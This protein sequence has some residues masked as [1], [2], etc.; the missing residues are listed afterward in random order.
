MEHERLQMRTAQVLT[1]LLQQGGE[2]T[3]DQIAHGL[4]RKRL[5]TLDLNALA[6]L[7]ASGRIIAEQRP[8]PRPVGYITVYRATK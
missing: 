5:N 8:G 6:R 7:Q 1:L 3:C 2:W 4:G